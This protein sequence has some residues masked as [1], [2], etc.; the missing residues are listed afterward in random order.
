MSKAGNM[1]GDDFIIDRVTNEM[2]QLTFDL[3]KWMKQ[4]TYIFLV[5]SQTNLLENKNHIKLKAHYYLR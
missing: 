3:M 2:N 5:A 1:I 4:L